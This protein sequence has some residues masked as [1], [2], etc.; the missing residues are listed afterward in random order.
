[1]QF[2]S[3]FSDE[4]MSQNVCIINCS[5]VIRCCDEVLTSSARLVTYWFEFLYVIDWRYY[6]LPATHHRIA[7]YIYS[8]KG[9]EKPIYIYTII[10][11][12][13]HSVWLYIVYTIHSLHISM[14]ISWI[15]DC[16]KISDMVCM[17]SIISSVYQVII[18]F[19]LEIGIFRDYPIFGQPK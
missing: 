2:P 13:T 19:T 10:Y 5:C 1:M 14:S 3:V 6:C 16:S 12:Y 9:W 7:V 8:S 17:G 4:K 15:W 11:T 18:M